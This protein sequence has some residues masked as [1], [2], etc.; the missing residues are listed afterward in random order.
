M[1]LKTVLVVEDDPFIRM[2][3][4]TL[5]R[6]AGHEV[7]ELDSADGAL[8]YVWRQPRDVAA[9]FSDV[10]LPGNTDGAD[11]ARTVSLHW[12]HITLLMTSGRSAETI[13]LPPNSRF[14]AKPWLPLDVL[15]GLQSRLD[16]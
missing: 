8:A 12:P 9:I 14:L 15:C 3:A 7:V 1:T 11:L 13:G 5:I 10:E 2:D 4:V 16:A 6:E